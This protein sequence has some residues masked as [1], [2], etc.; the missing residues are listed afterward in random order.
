MKIRI[1]KSKFDIWTILMSM[2]L[3]NQF[4]LAGAVN[5]QK[6]LLWSVLAIYGFK[7]LPYIKKIQGDVKR[8][9]SIV[10]IA[11]GIWALMALI[12]PYAHGTRDY[13]YISYS[14]GFLSWFVYLFDIIVRLAKKHPGADV[15]DLFMQ[16]FV[17]CMALYVV[18]TILILLFPALR[19]IV[20]GVVDQSQTQLNLLARDKYY[21]RIGWAGFSGYSTSL[22]CT[23]AICFQLIIIM[24]KIYA[25]KRVEIKDI[26]LYLLLLLGN[27]FYT[28][29]GV[30]LS[31]LCTIVAIF[32][33]ALWLNKVLA[34]IKYFLCFVVALAIGLFVLNSYAGNNA[35]MDW[36]FEMLINYEQGNGVLSMSTSIIFNQMLFKIDGKTLLLGDG[37]YTSSSGGYYM[38]TDLGFMRLLLY[39]GVI[40]TGLVYWILLYMLRKISKVSKDK[41]ITLLTILLLITFCGFEF[42]GESII[43]LL[44]L[45]FVLLLTSGFEMCG[46]QRSFNWGNL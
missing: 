11:F 12:L 29:T 34:F 32:S 25:G 4:Y 23:V 5:V 27:F 3:F 40:F 16:L 44:P 41:T 37:L 14:I 21:T 13:S 2:Y 7:Y 24:R 9:C 42:K 28:R 20:I 33:L 39:G 10:L 17:L 30:L 15:Q 31:L 38:K 6:I 45:V 18:S 43:L 1:R 26:L 46:Y 22:K 19:E 8:I 36:I 35:V